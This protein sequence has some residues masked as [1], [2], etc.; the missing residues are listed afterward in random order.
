MSNLTG[1]QLRE[2]LPAVP[3]DGRIR[4]APTFNDT[5]DF[6][7]EV[8]FRPKRT[9]KDTHRTVALLNLPPHTSILELSNVICGGKLVSLHLS[10]FNPGQHLATADSTCMGVAVFVLGIEARAFVNHAQCHPPRIRDTSIR[11]VLYTDAPTYPLSRQEDDDIFEHGHTRSLSVRGSPDADRRIVVEELVRT[12]IPK[13]YADA[14]AVVDGADPEKECVVHLN[15]IYA[16]TVAKDVLMRYGK[17]N[18]CWISNA[19]DP[20]DR[21][22]SA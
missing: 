9:T 21:P 2:P 15:S 19:P 12:G 13:M 10:P 17:R 22:I 16:M 4:W 3:W 6:F 8:R 7:N 14:A 11:A 20:C 1:K 5:E 18:K